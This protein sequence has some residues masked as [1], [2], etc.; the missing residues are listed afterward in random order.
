MD[1]TH[2]IRMFGD[3]KKHGKNKGVLHTVALP[4]TLKSILMQK[5]EFWKFK[6]FIMQKYNLQKK[7]STTNQNPSRYHNFYN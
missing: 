7:S 4:F 2:D 1:E 5:K 6:Y 3:W